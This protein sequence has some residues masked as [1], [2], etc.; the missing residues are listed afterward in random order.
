M[1][2]DT[3]VRLCRSGGRGQSGLDLA[4][5]PLLPQRDGT[6]PIPVNDVERVLAEI[7]PDYRSV[8]FL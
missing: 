2:A 7:D 4:T 6:A 8:A 1:H 5:R 3:D